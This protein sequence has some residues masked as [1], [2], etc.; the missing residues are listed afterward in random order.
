MNTN[1]DKKLCKH[2][3]TEIPKKAKVCPNCRKK[4]GSMIGNIVA[5]VVII[6]FVVSTFGGKGKD[7][8]T[9]STPKAVSTTSNAEQESSAVESKSENRDVD[10]T[11]AVGDIVETSDLR[12]SFLSAGQWE[13]GNEFISPKEGNVFYR[14]EFEFENISNSDQTISSMMSW[15]CYAD[16]YSMTQSWAAD[17]ILDATISP[18]KKAKGAVYYEV[19]EDAE[20][21]VI[22][23]ETNFWTENKVIFVVK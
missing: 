15:N 6:F 21:I 17:D 1:D 4:Q 9:D 12:I 11:F 14:F 10:N 23:Y 3:Q 20:S 16:D 13:S 22:E 18:G 19:P 2:C 8:A 5:I 7:K